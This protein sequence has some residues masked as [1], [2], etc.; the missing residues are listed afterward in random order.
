MNISVIECSK[1]CLFWPSDS[2]LP[3]MDVR[4]QTHTQPVKKSMIQTG[5]WMAA[6]QIVIVQ[7]LFMSCRGPDMHG[8]DRL[9]FVISKKSK[10][11]GG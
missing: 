11:L 3:L 10:D 7:K 9:N 5:E 1:Q 2:P 8:F 4:F 6:C